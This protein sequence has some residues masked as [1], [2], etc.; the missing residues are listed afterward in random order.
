MLASP[1]LLFV[2]DSILFCDATLQNLMYIWLVLTFFEV[3]TGLRVNLSKSV[4]VLVGDV[5]NLR[6]LSDIMGCRIGYLSMFYLGMPLEANFKSK[7]V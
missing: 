7:T 5:P 2:D 3:V 4:M 1:H 6:V